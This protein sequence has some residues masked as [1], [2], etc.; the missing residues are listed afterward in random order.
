MPTV[1][2]L[3]SNAYPRVMA[4][5]SPDTSK[6]LIVGAGLSG[7]M[8][9]HRLSA[10]GRRVLVVDKGRSVGGRLATRRL[11]GGIL[12]HGA[13]FF[14]TRSAEF[15]AAVDAWVDA[16][17]VSEWNR[18]FGVEDGYPRYRTNGG[19]SQLAKHVAATLDPELVSVVTRVRAQALL[20]MGDTWGVSYEGGAREVDE[21]G[22]VIVTSP[23][24]QTIELLTDGAVRLD[25]GV[26]IDD[27]RSIT[28]HR[29][30]ALLATVDGQPD[31]GSAG[32][33]Q[34]PDDPDFSFIADNMAKGISPT[35]AV[36][37]HVSHALSAELFDRPNSEITEVL[38][39]KA[40]RAL[41]SAGIDGDHAIGEF[42]VKKWRYAGPVTPRSERSLTIA[43]R[44]GPLVLAGD[45]FGGSKVEGAFL[46]GLAA[47]DAIGAAS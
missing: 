37:F 19:M 42:Q 11:G 18:G 8:A 27:L 26:T 39:P 46:S 21:A 24:P 15:T 5:D 20:Q 28:Y 32:A 34:Q 33:L 38:L 3:P 35:R 36:T 45:A 31:F 40:R 12:D 6:T 10:V 43:A 30:I 22:S 14:T 7:L 13:Q 29:V 16:G 47:A 44:P 17:V 1:E 9:A 23:V 41:S 25:L 2:C 4:F